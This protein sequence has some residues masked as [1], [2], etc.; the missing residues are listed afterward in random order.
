VGDRAVAVELSKRLASGSL[1]LGWEDVQPEFRSL[2]GSGSPDTRRLH[3]QLAWRVGRKI[4]LGTGFSRYQSGSGNGEFTT[5]TP[6][7]HVLIQPFLERQDQM[8]LQQLQL[9]LRLSRPAYEAASGAVD[10]STLNHFWTLSTALQQWQVS[11]SY[12]GQLTRDDV[13]PASDR[14]R[15]GL[16][17]S[18]SHPS[19]IAFSGVRGGMS[20]MLNRDADGLDAAPDRN[21]RTQMRFRSD[22]SAGP[23]LYACGAGLYRV[24]LAQGFDYNR[25]DWDV[26]LSHRLS[27]WQDLLIGAVVEG[28]HRTSDAPDND[29][30]LGEITTRVQL[31]T[32][33]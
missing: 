19:L 12:S 10:R 29:G 22:G 16:G 33:F 26:S 17:L 3:G 8:E 23:L 31:Q 7:M 14:S 27:G 2:S 32:S 21:A 24:D 6:S 28:T 18:L 9:A 1:R 5:T 20:L 25:L 11:L 4:R 30:D 13:A 15:D